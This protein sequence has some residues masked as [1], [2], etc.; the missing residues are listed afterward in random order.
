[1][2]V[3]FFWHWFPK[4]QLMILWSLDVLYRQKSHNTPPGV[5][6]VLVKLNGLIISR[7]VIMLFLI[8]LWLIIIGRSHQ[9]RIKLA[10][11]IIFWCNN[12]CHK[13][14]LLG[15]QKI[16]CIVWGER[17]TTGYLNLFTP[18]GYYCY[19]VSVYSVNTLLL[20]IIDTLCNNIFN[21]LLQ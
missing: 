3:V 8:K 16:F 7:Q 2:M 5:V 15:V 14:I 6:C 12:V 9:V 17:D 20:I 10:Y 11:L 18:S 4:H 13:V 19:E 21:L 1:M